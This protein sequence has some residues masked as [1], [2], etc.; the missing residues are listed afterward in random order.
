[1]KKSVKRYRLKRNYSKIG[2]YLKELR[3]ASN[4]TQREVSMTLGYSSAQFISN[5]ESG[6]S[7][8]PLKKLAAMHSLYGGDAVRL[9]DLVIS[10]ERE[11][12]LRRLQA[13]LKRKPSKLTE[14]PEV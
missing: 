14:Q 13:S 2:K 5:F 6:I 12:L 4:L 1:M 9:V 10:S 7:Y 3:L 8:P 11:L